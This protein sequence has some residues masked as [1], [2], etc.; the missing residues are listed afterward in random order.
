VSVL[1]QAASW[2]APSVGIAVVGGRCSGGP[3]GPAGP[4]EELDRYGGVDLVLP[5][6]SVTKVLVAYAVMVAVEEEAITL[7]EPAGPPG[8]TVRHLL[9]HAAGYAFESG[10]A[11]IARPGS[12]RIYSN[13]GFDVLAAHLEERTGIAM[14]TYLDEAVL[15]PLGMRASELVGSAGSGVRSCVADLA[16]FATELISP[17]LLHPE[18]LAELTRIQF[19]GLPGVLPGHGR[20]DPLDW[21]LGVERNFG[22]PGHWAGTRISPESFGHFGAHGTFVWVDPTRALG[23]V[24][25]SGRDFGPWARQA[26]PRLCDDVVDSCG[27]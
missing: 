18:T 2:D 21:G 17:T 27:R 11:V 8:A 20:Y 15:A 10:S 23:C 22:R 14:A 9:A 4:V 13:Q 26:W 5:I 12:R 6:A 24:C 3:S 16:L 19:P 7:D 25:V 1:E